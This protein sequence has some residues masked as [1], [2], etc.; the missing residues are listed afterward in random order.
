MRFFLTCK[1][2]SEPT[3]VLQVLTEN[4]GLLGQRQGVLFL[5]AEW[6]AWGSCLHW[7]L[8]LPKFHG[9]SAVIPDGCCGSVSELRHTDFR[10]IIIFQEAAKKSS[11]HLFWRIT[12]LLPC[13]EQICSLPKEDTILVPS[14]YLPFKNSQK[15]V[16]LSKACHRRYKNSMENYLLTGL[17]DPDSY[18]SALQ[19]IHALHESFPVCFTVLAGCSAPVITSVFQTRRKKRGRKAVF[20]DNL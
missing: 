9:T 8:L 13:S 20:K 7:V 10:K 18:L 15:D 12:S 1:L 5:T 17:R 14:G 6:A 19:D 11:Q 4:T 2:T 16:T 3:N